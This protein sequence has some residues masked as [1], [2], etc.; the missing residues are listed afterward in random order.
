MMWSFLTPIYLAGGAAL[1]IPLIVHFWNRQAVRTYRFSTLRFLTEART[2]S[3]HFR[4]LMRLLV[5]LLRLAALA[6]LVLAFA[7]PWKRIV[8]PPSGAMS[9]LVLDVSGSMK[10]GSAWKDA[11][12][13]ALDW[14][15]EESARSRTA[16]VL[17]GKSSRTLAGFEQTP[18]DQEKALKALTPTFESTNPE[19]ALRAADH[20][21]ESQPAKLK[22][23]TVISDLAASGWRKVNWE[24]PLAPGVVCDVRTIL[25]TPPPNLAV[26]EVNVPRSFWQTNVSFTVTA[27]LCNFASTPRELQVSCQLQQPEKRAIGTQ[28]L[29]MAGKESREV[30]FSVTSPVLK[31]LCGSVRV[32]P[33]DA[34]PADDERFFVISA[35]HQQRVGRLALDSKETDGFLKTALMPRM[36]TADN[37]YQW[38]PLTPQTS[39]PLKEKVD[40]VFLDQGLPLPRAAADDLHAFVEGGGAAVI[41]LGDGDELADWEKDWLPVKLGEKRTTSALVR[42]QHFAQVKSTHPILRPFSLPRG[43]D[44]FRVNVRKWREFQAPA[45]QALIQLANGDPILSV[46]PRGE[47][48]IIVV[49]FPFTREWSDWPIQSTFLPLVYQILSWLEQGKPGRTELLAGEAAPDGSLVAQPG[50]W[51]S[52]Q[53]PKGISAVNV[54]PSESD[55]TRWTA[56]VNFKQLENPDKA[57]AEITADPRATLPS[58]NGAASRDLQSASLIGWLLIATALFSLSELLMANRTPR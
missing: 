42:A 53:D 26:T 28:K 49:A 54:D 47:G 52:D 19:T 13:M 57:V 22:K 17:M 46:I 32:E 45:G 51:G 55:L 20:L 36:K 7:Q 12:D 24:Q 5:L 15:K 35:R 16:I 41:F 6:G 18:A 58:L 25:P 56:V 4:D 8:L 38:V 14:L 30:S 21:L 37:R 2:T 43:G 29:S 34:M 11:R 50:F 44:L 33:A 23:I 10:A 48:Q 9:V 3:H 31:T 39:Q 27:T 40:M 1:L